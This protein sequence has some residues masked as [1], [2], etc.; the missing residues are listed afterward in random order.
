MFQGNVL[1]PCQCSQQ[2][3]CMHLVPGTFHCQCSIT[4]SKAVILST[5]SKAFKGGWNVSGC[6]DTFI[7]LLRFLMM[8][9]CSLC[10]LVLFAFLS[11]CLSLS[12]LRSV[13]ALRSAC[14]PVCLAMS[15]SA[16]IYKATMSHGNKATLLW[17]N[18]FSLSIS[19]GVSIELQIH[20]SLQRWSC[21]KHG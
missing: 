11:S 5:Q 12:L 16:P 13:C 20:A 10:S 9:V 4:S 21:R 8:C 18:F 19:A 3:S 15:I 6:Q 7:V 17:Y 2:C 14:S 1:Y